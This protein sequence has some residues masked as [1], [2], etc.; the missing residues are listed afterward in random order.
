MLRYA[1]HVAASQVSVI[2]SFIEGLNDHLHPF[3]STGKPLNYL[4]AVEIAKRAEA[5]L[6]RS[7]NRVPTQHHQSGRQQFSSSGS[8]SLRPRGKQF[9]KPGSSSSSSGNRGGYRYSGPYCDHCGGKHSSNQCVG[10]QGVCNNCGRPGHFS[11]VCPSKTG[12]SAQAG[13]G[14]QSNRIPTASQSSH[15]PSRPS[16]QSRG[17]GGPQNQSSVHVFSLT[18]DEAQAAPDLPSHFAASGRGSGSG[19]R[20]G[21]WIAWFC[22]VESP[23]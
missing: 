11:R 5:S 17:Q 3:V 20:D 8:A 12:K 16:H 6:K 13:S 1:P 2:E 21:G 15:Q 14:A 18:E 9:K 10:V 22:S 7:G 19:A 4:E 23:S